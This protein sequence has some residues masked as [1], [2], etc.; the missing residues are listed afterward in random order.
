MVVVW[1]SLAGGDAEYCA[2]IVAMNT[3]LTIGLYSPSVGLFIN[4]LPSH[5]GID[6]SAE[7]HVAMCEVAKNGGIY[8]STSFVMTLLT[9]YAVTKAKGATWYFDK[10]T[11]RI[12]VLTLMALH[13]KRAVRLAE[14]AHLV[15]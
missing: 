12:G 6:S 5:L 7:I 13:D 2:A 4:D 10:F 3:V 9:W 8:V 14:H 1:N 11:P 15:R